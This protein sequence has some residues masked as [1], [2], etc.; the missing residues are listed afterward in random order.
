MTVTMTEKH[1]I[2]IPK[3]I[4][5]AMGLHK[6]SLFD[7]QIR[8]NRIELTPVEVKEKEFT[9]EDYRLMD[10]LCEKEQHT[11]K[12]MTPAVIKRIAEGDA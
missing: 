9:E 5:D 8:K 4:A 11:A 7:V 2:T 10:A 12:R 1:Q 6:G 3:K